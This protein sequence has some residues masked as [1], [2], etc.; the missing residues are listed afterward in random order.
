[1][2]VFFKGLRHNIF[3]SCTVLFIIFPFIPPPL[4]GGEMVIEHIFNPKKTPQ[5]VI[6]EDGNVLVGYYDL[7]GRAVVK[8]PDGQSI[9]LNEG[10]RI[11]AAS[12]LFLLA[13]G[14]R[15]YAVWREKGKG[16]KKIFFR[17]SLNNGVDWNKEIVIDES[18]EPLTRIKLAGDNKGN[19]YIAWLGERFY[20]DGPHIPSSETEEQFKGHS[21]NVSYHIYVRYSPNSGS[22]W[23][24]TLRLTEGF[25]DSVWPTILSEGKKAYSFLWTGKD[26][27]RYI[28]FRKTGNGNSWEPPVYIKKTGDVLLITPLKAGKR[29]FVFWFGRYGNF[30]YVIEGAYSDDDGRTWNAF[31]LDD[32]RGLDIGSWDISTSGNM[33]YLTFS[34]RTA[35]KTSPWKQNIYFIASADRGQTWRDLK[36]LRHY[37]FPHTNALYPSISADGNGEVVVVWNDFRNIRGDLYINYSS[38]YGKKWKENDF[39]IGEKGTENTFL[40]PFIKSL[41]RIK[42]KYYILSYRYRND[43]FTGDTELILNIFSLRSLAHKTDMMD[44]TGSP[45]KVSLLKKRANKFWESMINADY[46]GAYPLFDPFFRANFR[47]VDYLSATGRINYYTYV[48]KDVKVMGNI[49]SIEVVYEYEIPTLMTRLGKVSRPRTKAHVTETWVFVRDN[50]YKEYHNEVGGFSYTR[51]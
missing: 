32:T 19:L 44:D 33:V 2:R 8:R 17:S 24:N 48:I 50:W 49:G 35:R 27:K 18:T 20:N 7:K 4:F 28:I 36:I 14:K 29:L 31:I 43:N 42:N 25:Y 45:K 41:L 16:K 9:I 46:R 15:I 34:A 51:Y 21:K 11:G 23:N 26:G 13:E 39:A 5:A 40:Y 30:D 3:V 38:D 1:M 12:G 37:P 10:K 6:T 22:T 47:D